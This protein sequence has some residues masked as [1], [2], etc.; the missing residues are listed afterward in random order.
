MKRLKGDKTQ[1]VEGGPMK[2]PRPK[3]QNES[4]GRWIS[5]N[6]LSNKIRLGLRHTDCMFQGRRII[7]DESNT[8]S[9]DFPLPS[10]FDCSIQFSLSLWKYKFHKQTK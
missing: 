5:G 8:V 9:T 3:R 10:S 7:F 1:M 4:Y 2:D 6:H